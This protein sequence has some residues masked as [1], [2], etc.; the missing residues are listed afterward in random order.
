MARA[1]RRALCAVT[2]A[3]F[4]LLPCAP[5]LGAAVPP[6]SVSVQAPEN[7]NPVAAV[8]VS[9]QTH[10]HLPLGG[11]YYA[12][13]ALSS[14]RTPV[15]EEPRCAVSSDMLRTEYAFPRTTRQVRMQ[16]RLFPA[17]FGNGEWCPGGTYVGAIYAVPH[18]P[19]CTRAYPCFG[20][21]S[22]GPSG[23][24]CGVVRRPTYGYS[25]PGGLPKPIDRKSRMVGRFTL[26]F[27]GRG[28]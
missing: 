14:Y 27:A 8:A 17:P 3:L 16:L 6:R 5:S 22:C 15:G 18:P 21:G 7:A 19:P 1:S 25:Y 13:A 2:L 26:T 23:G 28:A 20:R 9:F 10:L 24:V 11:Y 4:V 12:V